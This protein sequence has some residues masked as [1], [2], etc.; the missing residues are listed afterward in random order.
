MFR[1]Q[2]NPFA[3]AA[4]LPLFVKLITLLL[5]LSA[6]TVNGGNAAS[7]VVLRLCWMLPRSM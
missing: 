4:F 7:L 3:P 5:V 1:W 2:D 6:L